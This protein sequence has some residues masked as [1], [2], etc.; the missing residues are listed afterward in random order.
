VSSGHLDDVSE[1]TTTEVL[2]GKTAR[3]VT[4]HRRIQEITGGVPAR[5]SSS[6]TNSVDPIGPNRRHLLEE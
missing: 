2:G 4:E 1:A 6:V 5:E 3:E